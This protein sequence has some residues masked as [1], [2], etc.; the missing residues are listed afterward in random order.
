M[1]TRLEK[2]KNKFKDENNII[3]ERLSEV[4][5]LYLEDFTNDLKNKLEEEKKKELK[6]VNKVV[7]CMVPLT[8]QKKYVNKNMYPVLQNENIKMISGEKNDIDMLNDLKNEISR[9]KKNDTN[10]LNNST[11]I[12]IGY[13]YID[14]TLQKIKDINIENKFK[15]VLTDKKGNKSEVP[16]YLCQSDLIVR[17]CK[18]IWNMSK[19]YGD[20]SPIVYMPYSTR[21]FYIEIDIETILGK[22]DFELEELNLC[23]ADN[24]LSEKIICDKALLWNVKIEPAGIEIE[25]Y[26]NPIGQMVYWRYKFTGL[27]ENKYIMPEN[28]QWPSFDIK[29]ISDTE[30]EM[31]FINKP[32]DEFEG[33][34]IYDIKKEEFEGIEIYTTNYNNKNLDKHYRIRSLSDIR[35]ELNKFESN[36]EDVYIADICMKSQSNKKGINRYNSE[37]SI[38]EKGRFGYKNKNKVFIEFKGDCNYNFFEDYANFVIETLTYLYPEIGWEGVY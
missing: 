4:L 6:P 26:K 20:E 38:Y 32:T 36:N 21:L 2:L 33:I 9:L 37:M 8:E 27:Q 18:K 34:R 10:D 3:G 23:F 12:N 28:I 31:D 35:Y 24:G 25:P 1:Q 29:V 14:G 7:N 17:K 19:L 22:Q 5:G 13:L 11:R 30:I 16:Y 15:A